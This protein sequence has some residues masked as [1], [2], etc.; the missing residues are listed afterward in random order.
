MRFHC[1]RCSILRQ[2]IDYAKRSPSTFSWMQMILLENQKMELD[3]SNFDTEIHLHRNLI[4]G[5][6]DPL[7]YH[8]I[9]NEIFGRTMF[10][11]M[12]KPL[13]IVLFEE[14]SIIIIVPNYKIYGNGNL[15][16]GNFCSSTF[17]ASKAHWTHT[18][19]NIR[20]NVEIIRIPV[21]RVTKW[22]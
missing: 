21:C 8:I 18:L 17:L 3:C 5:N 14:W 10:E 1:I 12:S 2:I 9:N 16:L 7:P 20:E 4:G 6:S 15:N 19:Y 22:Y 13:Q 11:E